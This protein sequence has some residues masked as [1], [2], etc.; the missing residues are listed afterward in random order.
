MLGFLSG[1]LSKLPGY[2]HSRDPVVEENAQFAELPAPEVVPEEVESV[3]E[4]II[5]L[6]KTLYK[7]EWSTRHDQYCIDHQIY[8]AHPRRIIGVYAPGRKLGISTR[9]MAER[10]STMPKGGFCSIG[11]HSYSASSLPPL[12]KVGRFCSIAPDVQMMGTQHPTQRFSSSPLTYTSRFVAI[13]R[14][15]HGVDYELL[16]FQKY[17]LPA[18]IGND[19]W[20]GQGALLKGGVRIGDGAIVAARSIVTKDVPP[21]AIVGGAPASIRKYRFSE[22]QV[23]RMISLRWWRYSYVELPPPSTWDDIDAFMDALEEKIANGLKPHKSERIRIGR[24]F[25]KL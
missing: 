22:A 13:A 8:L 15:E 7:F 6:R 24:D 19:V 18:V 4:K 14:E 10:H 3:N 20:I 2:R 12:T 5:R 25:S 16:P 1:F 23:E 21:Y 11:R 17:T 9:V